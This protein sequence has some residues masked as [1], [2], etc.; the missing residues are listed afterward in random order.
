MPDSMTLPDAQDRLLAQTTWDKNVVVTAGAGTGKTTILVNRMLNLLMREPHPLAMNEI[1]ALTFTNKA[2]TEMK[3]RLRREL[4]KLAERTDDAV[5]ELF[6]TRYRLSSEDVAQRAQEALAQF[7][8]SQ[9]GTLHSF[10]AHL[11]RLHPLESGLDPAF[12]KD[13]GTRFNE[14]FD[15]RWRT[16]LADEL[17]RTG[18]RHGLW[19]KVLAGMGLDDLRDMAVTLAGESVDLQELE[20]QCREGAIDGAVRDWLEQL[21]EKASRLVAGR[22]TA[23]PLKADKMLSAALRCVALVL[24][25]G[26]QGIA[27]LSDEDRAL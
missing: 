22:A 8:K 25:Q 11:L 5:T 14:L 23:K 18:A 19:R 16:W 4:T 15:S 6:R 24:E 20:T 17:G 12:Q 13:D 21:H 27:R 26:T 1:V 3:Q 10:A 2:A 9:I 7:E